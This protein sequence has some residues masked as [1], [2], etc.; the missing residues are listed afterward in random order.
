MPIKPY[1]LPAHIK[2]YGANGT[3]DRNK[4]DPRF[5]DPITERIVASDGTYID[6]AFSPPLNVPNTLLVSSFRR[7]LFFW[8]NN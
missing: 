1:E 8:L 5:Y 4:Y 7:S 6:I 3:Y 2:G